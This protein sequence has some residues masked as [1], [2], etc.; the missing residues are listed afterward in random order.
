MLDWLRRQD[1]ARVFIEAPDVT[2]TFGEI[3]HAVMDR[4]VHGIEVVR[5][6][7]DIQSVID[8]LAVMS[9]GSAVVTGTVETTAIDPSDAASVLFTSGTSGRPKGVRLTID[10]WAAAASA[11]IQHLG[12]GPADTWL[13]ALPLHHVA[14]LSILVRSAYAG[15]AVRM[16]PGFDP[17][18]FA[19]HLRRGVSVVSMVPTMLSRVLD[20]DPGP[21]DGLKAVLL[22]GGPIPSRVLDRAGAAGLPVLP[23]YG[24]TETAGQVATL[25]PGAPLENKAHPLPGV[26]IRVDPD[27]RIA[28]R[29][30]M[31]S[32]GYVGE[33]D[34]GA[35]DWLV[36]GDLGRIDD[37]GALRVTGRA[38]T[39]IV[40]GGE[41]I[42]PAVVEAT[43]LR[44]EGVQEALV[45]GLTS[46]E[47][48]MEAVCL[49]VGQANPAQLETALRQI[50][51]GFMVPKR[52][53]QV[54]GLPMTPMGKP[55]RDEAARLFR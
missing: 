16:L 51:P 26:D 33:P 41:N 53:R 8:L 34:R 35:E 30:P 10:N 32:P 55:D 1:P 21:Y 46:E 5:P 45:A 17:V 14:G 38:D 20:V 40:S 23:T 39:I 27:D 42:D 47:W 9:K 4:P 49:Y 36:T 37:D 50:L 13:L 6:G 22:G 18:A 43:L 28:V 24:L 11:S 3:A 54:A 15:G 7:L 2:L 19:T 48:G 25:K 29:G 31:L 44:V 52:W 12:H